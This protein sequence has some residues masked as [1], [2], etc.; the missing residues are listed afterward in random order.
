M[1]IVLGVVLLIIAIVAICMRQF[2]AKPHLDKLLASGR[3]KIGETLETYR[4]TKQALGELGD[5]NAVSEEI[6]VMGMPKCDEPL[7]SPVGNK[8]CIY[9]EMQVTCK[10]FERRQQKDA[11]GNLMV[12]SN[13]NPVMT[14]TP[15]EKKLESRS[16]STR[17]KIDDGTGEV[18]V[19]PTGGSFDGLVKFEK[20]ESMNSSSPTLAIGNYSLSLTGLGL[21]N[22]NVRPGMV[23]Y[24]EKIIGLDRRLTVVGNLCDKMGDLII[25]KNGKSNVIVSTKSQDEMIAA[26]K[27]TV[28]TQ[29]IVAVAC[30]AVGFVLT[31]IGAIA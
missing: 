10:M 8:P 21:N 22:P 4:E 14:E 27:S 19:D 7:I 31:I 1:F 5:E 29:L 3:K 20:S 28:K 23:T 18:L 12:D 6:T 16:N 25:E 13:G 2:S 15:V 17:F 24:E 11:N 9:Y 30:G 26:A